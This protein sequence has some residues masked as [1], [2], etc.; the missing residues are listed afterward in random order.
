MYVN[1][2]RDLFEDLG[3]RNFDF[4]SFSNND[5]SQ[6]TEEIRE[7]QNSQRILQELIQKTMNHAKTL[8]NSFL[9][10]FGT[11]AEVLEIFKKEKRFLLNG[12]LEKV[13]ATLNKIQNFVLLKDVRKEIIK[14]MESAIIAIEFRAAK[15]SKG[16]E[17]Y[18][19]SIISSISFKDEELNSYCKSLFEVIV[20]NVI[21]TN[22]VTLNPLVG[23]GD[24]NTLASRRQ[25]NILLRAIVRANSAA[26]YRNDK[27]LV[28]TVHLTRYIKSYLRD[29]YISSDSIVYKANRKVLKYIGN[30]A[31]SRNVYIS[32][33]KLFKNVK[34]KLKFSID[35]ELKTYVNTSA[36]SN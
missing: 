30:L 10:K 2:L 26:D 4:D 1:I 25:F 28:S 20:N 36:N 35:P 16:S 5:I 22:A 29:L 31:G 13:Q 18:G 17:N 27:I 12:I 24:N 14:L 15:Y 34:V 3:K 33:D 7:L 21:M 19:I 32:D 11:E 9:S 23:V 6:S 8:D